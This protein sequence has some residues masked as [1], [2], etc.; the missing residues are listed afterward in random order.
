MPAEF[1]F[2]R[3]AWLLLLP[4]LIALVPLLCRARAPGGPWRRVID[5]ALLP[6]L[7]E[8]AAP[9]RRCLPAALLGLLWVLLALGLAGPTWER[10][11]EPLLETR[12]YHVVLLDLSPSMNAADLAPSRLA[13]ARFEVLDLLRLAADGQTALVAFGPEPY[14]VAPLTGDAE[15]IALQVPLLETGLLPVAGERRTDLALAL[16]GE[17]LDGAAA[18]AGSVVLVSDGVGPRAASL[19]AAE[20]LRAAGHQ[21]HVLAVGT[22]AGA[23]LAQDGGLLRG[24]D[25]SVR[26]A[27]LDE[28][29]LRALAVT[30]GG[31]YRA[32]VAGDGDVQALV[33]AAA[34]ERAE[35]GQDSTVRW[36]D[37]GPWLVLAAL[38]LA[39]LGFRR[40][41]LGPL[42]LALAVLP[43]QA[44]RAGAWD[45]LWLT[46]DQQGARAL[47]DGRAGA[48]QALFERPDW[49]AAAAH[50]AGDYA[51]ALQAL[52]GLPPAQSAY[53]RGNL[54]ARQGDY[55]AAIEAYETALAANPQDDDARYNRDLLRALL[56]R[57]QAAQEGTRGESDQNNVSADSAGQEGQDPASGQSSDQAAK[58]ARSGRDPAAQQGDE[59]ADAGDSGAPQS[60]PAAAGEAAGDADA[61][62]AQS[63]AGDGA[64]GQTGPDGDPGASA[65][66]GAGEASEAAGGSTSAGGAGTA[67]SAGADPAAQGGA[68]GRGAGAEAGDPAD[69]DGARAG[70]GPGGDAVTDAAANGGGAAQPGDDPGTADG[71]PGDEA[72]GTAAQTSTESMDSQAGKAA[73]NGG[74]DASGDA[75]ARDGETPDG[76]E[77]R[78]A[79]GSPAGDEAASAASE[80]AGQGAVQGEGAGSDT[81][82][83]SQ[84]GVAEAGSQ[85]EPSGRQGDTPDSAGHGSGPGPDRAEGATPRP[86]AD[87]QAPGPGVADTGRVGAEPGRP[88]LADLLGEDAPAGTGQVRGPVPGDGPDERRQALE[89]MLRTVEDDPGGLLRQ[90]FLLQHLR[91]SGQLP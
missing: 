26:L 28:D 46:P 43:P 72:S 48:A 51:A 67:T 22:A 42:V 14:L 39:L 2:L 31:L 13:R 1:H 35:G 4:L 50:A 17:L 78:A 91:R 83:Q 58:D 56:D 47:D 16:A 36:R 23:P 89:Q 6:H 7:L 11:P 30:G 63:A 38:P 57:Q 45:D 15:T 40:G 41:W 12:Q 8:G 75:Q 60:G 82:G 71:K 61:E 76:Q 65:D 29:G 18:P 64:Q 70:Q 80:Q 20:R 69:D 10:E 33:A 79:A 90:R 27:R 34:R 74:S 9:G 32:A 5:P 85:G 55:R 86:G 52:D 84:A 68:Q 25:G 44:V 73:K 87:G 53:N 77:T 66:A 59:G 88:G 24:G 37:L 19:A 62:S 81:A 54:L 49:R 21:V 3:P